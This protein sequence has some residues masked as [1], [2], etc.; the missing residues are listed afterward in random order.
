MDVILT[1]ALFPNPISFFTKKELFKIPVFGWAMHSAGMVK[2]DRFNK[3]KSRQCVDDAID[4]I[5]NTHLSFLNYPEGTRSGYND[6]LDF[7]KGG[8]LLAIKSNA[9]ILPLTV[10]Y[11]KIDSP[12]YRSDATLVF[13]K[14]I[15]LVNYD[16]DNKDDLIH[17]TRNLI[18][19]NIEK[20]FNV[21]IK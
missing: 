14:P 15:R 2:V 11:K 17:Q 7:K 20:Y 8:F 10:I 19:S 16:I 13:D 12:I 3:D 9:S 5:Q 6:L 4:K 18:K 21:E 1:F